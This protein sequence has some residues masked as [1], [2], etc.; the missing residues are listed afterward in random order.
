MNA[1]FVMALAAGMFLVACSDS[2]DTAPVDC[3]TNLAT[4]EELALTP[5]EDENLELLAIVATSRVVAGQSQYERVVEDVEVIRTMRPDL[6]DIGFLPNF[7]QELVIRA[8]E[9]T[10]SR[11]VEGTYTAWDCLNERFKVENIRYGAGTPDRVDLELDGTYHIPT[12]AERYAEL[13]GVRSASGGVRIGDGSTICVTAGTTQWHYV[14]DQG[15]GD[16]ESGCID[17][18]Y[19]HFIS[20]NDGGVVAAGSWAERSPDP[21]PPWLDAYATP[22]ACHGDY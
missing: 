2:P 19:S 14:V 22:R 5:R 15:T 17:H 6:R 11:M 4:D 3:G 8:D 9:G 16:C 13:P 18:D 7:R 1:R 10:I 12:L 20:T 21:R